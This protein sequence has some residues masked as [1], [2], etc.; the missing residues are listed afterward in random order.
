MLT[1]EMRFAG[2]PPAF[3]CCLIIASSGAMYTQ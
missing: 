1:G 2:N 3:A